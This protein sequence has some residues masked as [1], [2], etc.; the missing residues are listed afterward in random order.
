MLKAGNFLTSRTTISFSRRALLHGVNGN[1]PSDSIKDGQFLSWIFVTSVEG[2]FP[3]Q[4]CYL[5]NDAFS[6]ALTV[7]R[8]MKIR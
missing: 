6:V 7:Y 5:F 3:M 2:F 1:E 4:V 8:R